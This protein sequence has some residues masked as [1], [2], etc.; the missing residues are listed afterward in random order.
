MVGNRFTRLTV[1]ADLGLVQHGFSTRP[2]RMVRCQCDCGKEIK[3]RWDHMQGGTTE[4]CGCLNREMVMA[5]GRGKNRS[6][7][8]IGEMYGSTVVIER[9]ANDRNGSAVY[10][11]LCEC[12]NIHNV[13]G[14]RLSGSLVLHCKKCGYREHLNKLHDLNKKP[15][16]EAA[17]RAAFLMTRNQCATKRKL[18]WNI[19]FEDW[20]RLT[21]MPCHY[22]D[23]PPSN[24]MRGHWN[25]GYT[26]NG[27][28]RVDNSVGYV[29][30]NVVPCCKQCNHA[31]SDQSVSDFLAWARR[32]SEHSNKL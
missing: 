30:T 9:I 28:D 5:S 16:G 27:L 20:K 18:I 19:S 10:K 6:K 25:G 29:I 31:K 2:R 14:A 22:C 7:I 4:S 1:V 13:V 24:H 21:V 26:Y 23:C 32:V 15:E 3:A 12:G 11:C 17:C 8:K